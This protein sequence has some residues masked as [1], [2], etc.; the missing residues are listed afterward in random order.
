MCVSIYMLRECKSSCCL[1]SLFKG[2]KNKNLQ[3]DDVKVLNA[4]ECVGL[5]EGSVVCYC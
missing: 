4:V 5:L 2:P 1:W 3:C